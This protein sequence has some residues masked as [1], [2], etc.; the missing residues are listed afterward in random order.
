[1]TTGPVGVAA[2]MAMEHAIG[3][4]IQ[5]A[6]EVGAEHA[7]ASA[8]TAEE[9]ERLRVSF[10]QCCEKGLG[11]AA[12][13]GFGKGIKAARGGKVAPQKVRFEGEVTHG[14]KATAKALGEAFE[15]EEVSVRLQFK[16]GMD[17]RDYARKI[18]SLKT[19][20]QKGS[21]FST[22][23][24]GVSDAERRALTRVYRTQA[25]KRIDRMFA[26]NPAAK[27]NALE[28]LKRSDIDHMVD[29]QL[30]GLNTTKNLRAMES[31][32][33]Q[34]LGRQVARQ[35]PKDKKIPVTLAK[36]E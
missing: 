12:V 21:L 8:S 32:T 30:G 23:P 2:L 31:F 36:S 4:S 17:K 7:A 35:L 33:N 34:D 1:M 26:D 14:R 18:E 22:T 9:G 3:A 28:R 24:H 5:A 20:E 13:L 27:F 10:N 11:F 6:V 15:A 29:L 19:A 16:E 25:V